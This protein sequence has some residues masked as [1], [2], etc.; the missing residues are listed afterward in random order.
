MLFT[1]QFC[2]GINYCISFQNPLEVFLPPQGYLS[3]PYFFNAFSLGTNKEVL[4]H[5]THCVA[6]SL[7]F[8]QTLFRSKLFQHIMSLTYEHVL[9]N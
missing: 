6:S 7:P 1:F 2:I 5:V 4:L 3:F 8:D 9:F